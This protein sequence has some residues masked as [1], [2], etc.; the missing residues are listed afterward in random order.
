VSAPVTSAQAPG[1]RACERDLARDG[2]R[3]FTVNAYSG[4]AVGNGADCG[5]QPSFLWMGNKN[6][7]S[8][9]FWG[10]KIILKHG[11]GQSARTITRGFKHSLRRSVSGM[12]L[13]ARPVARTAVT[14]AAAM[15]V[16]TA[17]QA[18]PLD[19]DTPES[20]LLRPETD[21]VRTGNVL[22]FPRFEYDI[23]H[24]TNIFNT[25]SFEVE[26]TVAVFRPSIAVEPD[27]ARHE[28][29]LEAD[30]MLRRYFDTKSENSDQWGVTARGRLDFA[31]RTSANASV[32]YAQ[33]IEPRGTFGDQFQTDE[34]LGFD[35]LEVRGGL[36]RTGGK[37]ELRAGGNYSQARYD[38]STLDGEIQSNEWRDEDSLGGFVR[39]DYEVSGKLRTF[40]ELNASQIDY[41]S[42]P[43]EAPRDSDGYGV[44]VGLRTEVS[45]LID[46]EAAIGYTHRSFD[47]PAVENFDGFNF[48]VSGRWTPTPRW[49]FGLEGARSFERSPQVNVPAVLQTRMRVVAQRSLGRRTLTGV[50]MTYDNWDYQGSDRN[51]S[52][53]GGELT[54]RYLIIDE[55]TAI[56]GAGYRKQTGSGVDTPREY[57]GAS[58]RVG[59]SVSL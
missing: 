28:I 52:R 27:L 1:R 21:G 9:D 18:Q 6:Q 10:S 35:V 15:A 20:L 3:S 33:R 22:I 14:L 31:E 16:H 50:E 48:R 37:L 13:F 54:L 8:Y 39:A 40:V 7:K 11:E 25:D 59:L 34:P 43:D 23:E 53:V 38:D 41:K 17:A 45:D 44:L 29:T 2:N 30:A 56:A 12:G 58:F 36:E 4:A 42:N 19:V 32:R 5:G 49:L 26:D 57:E 46:A 55:V 47:D 51:E 24:D